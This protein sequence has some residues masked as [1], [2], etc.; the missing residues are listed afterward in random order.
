[1]SQ[2]EPELKDLTQDEVDYFEERAAIIEE[3]NKGMSRREA[4]RRA[5]LDVEKKRKLF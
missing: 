1:L 5:M 4:E 3:G 2:Y